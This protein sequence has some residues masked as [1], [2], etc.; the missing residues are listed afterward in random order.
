MERDNPRIGYAFAV[1]IAFA[2][3]FSSAKLW[4]TDTEPLFASRGTELR[5]GGRLT[6]PLLECDVPEVVYSELRP[7]KYKVQDYVDKQF[8]AGKAKNIAVYFRDLN[9]GPWFGINALE[10]FSPASLLKVPVMIA[11]LRYANGDVSVLDTEFSPIL[12]ESGVSQVINPPEHLAEG[13]TYTIENLLYRMIAYSDNDAAATL[14]ARIDQKALQ[15]TFV[16]L[17]MVVPEERSLEDFMSVREYAS[18]FRILFNASYLSRTMSERGLEYLTRS[19]FTNGIVAG[20]P[21]GITVAHKFGERS[22]GEGVRQLHD[23]GIIYYPKRPYVLCV[24]TRGSDFE[25]Q[26]NV[27]SNISRI[28]WDEI[29]LQERS[30]DQ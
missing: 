21:A 5:S 9:N 14:I 7:F 23:C 4:P 29:D 13:K 28:V 22:L 16:D 30:K 17:G 2:L 12:A 19:S 10:N 8:T 3:G 25:K 24:M 18:F 27:I 6:N 1:L 20:V 15:Q 11:Y 26:A